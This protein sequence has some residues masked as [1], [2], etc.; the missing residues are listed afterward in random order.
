EGKMVQ[1]GLNMGPRHAQVVGWAVSHTKK[2][3]QH[4]RIVRDGDV[5]GGGALQWAVQQHE[6]PVE[7]N[8]PMNRALDKHWA[9]N[10][11]TRDI[12]EGLGYAIVMD[13]K[14]F[15]F[16]TMKRGPP[17]VYYSRGYSA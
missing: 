13:N 2:L 4:E 15:E 8:R 7:V 11:A 17:T 9:P 10:L 16:P 5:V 1:V 14:P 12:P 6:L 3:S